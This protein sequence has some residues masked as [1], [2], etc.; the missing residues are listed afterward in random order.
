M[1]ETAYDT[2]LYSVIPVLVFG[3]LG[4]ILVIIS[5]ARQRQLLKTN[6]YF[7]VLNLAVCDLGTLILMLLSHIVYQFDEKTYHGFFSCLL[8]VLHVPFYF[9]G[10]AMMLTISVL[11]YRATVHPL[12]PA[13]SRA[14]LI[15]VC[16]V[17]YA[18]GSFIGLGLPLPQCFDVKQNYPIYWRLIYGFDLFLYL[19]STI[20]MIGCYCKIGRALVKHTE[21]IKRMDSFAV[22]N[23][24]NRDR[25]IFLV[26]LCTVLCFSVGRLL[27]CVSHIWY[28]A[29]KYSYFSKGVWVFVVGD[30]L[31]VAG[32]YSANPLIYGILDKN[33]FR[34]LKLCKKK[35]QTPVELA[36]QETC[37][38]TH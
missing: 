1:E 13:I 5:L 35:R 7:L 38:T 21:Q 32:S 24:H 11:R 10:L 16:Y 6:Y 4:N 37:R 22:K 17:I 29:D 36:M 20:F 33:M 30:I 34:F 31:I 19:V 9:S 27:N 8:H 26:C 23:R 2:Y 12:K 28:F 3:I 25:R 15:K 14:K 18:V